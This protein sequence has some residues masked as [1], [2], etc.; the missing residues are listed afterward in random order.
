MIKHEQNTLLAIPLLRSRVAPVLNWC[1]T[2]F[3]IPMGEVDRALGKEIVLP[4]TSCFD[5]LRILRERKTST[6]ICGAL[7]PDLLD[8]C[9][10]LGLQVIHGIAGEIDEVLRAYHDGKLDDPRFRLPGYSVEEQSG[11]PGNQGTKCP[12]CH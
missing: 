8:Y 4:D 5:R 3:I 9:Q 2:F 6:L 1:T 11:A 12:K 10:S 7:S